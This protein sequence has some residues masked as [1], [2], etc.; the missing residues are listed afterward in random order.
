MRAK[1]LFVSLELPAPIVETLV[2][3][4]PHLPGVRWSAPE[5]IHL[6]VAFLGNV[7]LDEEEKLRARL[8]AIQFTS[9]FLPLSGL[10][11][12]PARGRPKIIWIGVGRGHP[13]LFQLHK[14]VTD[15][16]LGAGI[17]P[18]LGPWH[19]HFTLARCQDVAAQSIWAFLRTSERFDAGLV[20]IDSFQLKSSRLTPAGSEYTTE[21]SVPASG[22]ARASSGSCRSS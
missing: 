7:P 21:L 1:R 11:T 20:R 8:L 9:F 3:L 6:T 12:F 17:E 4:N 14:R 16:A 22:S 13:H 10:G 18:D 19:P 5:Q 15:A 2:R